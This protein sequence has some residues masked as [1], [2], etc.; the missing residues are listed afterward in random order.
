MTEAVVVRVVAIGDSVVYGRVDPAA[1]GWVS[2]LRARL[3]E[4]SPT[5]TAVFNLGIGGNTSRDVVERVDEIA[6][7]EPSFVV[8]GVGTNDA[9]RRGVPTAP[10]NV[11]PGEYEDNVARTVDAVRASGAVPVVFGLHPLDDSRPPGLYG[12]FHVS[13]DQAD[14][15]CRL[16]DLCRASSTIYLPI[17]AALSGSDDRSLAARS[18]LMFDRI[19]PN[20]D[21]HRAMFEHMLP[22]LSDLFGLELA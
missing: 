5:D 13:E 15:D 22:R 11:P 10:L 16:Q 19:H 20:G 21:G 14:Y 12:F 4:I 7:R 9:R 18:S 6:R 17:W 1:G 3:D 2:L 8:V